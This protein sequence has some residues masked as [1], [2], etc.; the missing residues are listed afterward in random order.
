[1]QTCYWQKIFIKKQLGGFSHTL[2][3]LGKD[4]TKSQR[5]WFVKLEFNKII[6]LKVSLGIFV[7]G[8]D[9]FRVFLINE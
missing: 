1:M 2:L 9:N 4:N 8:L 6:G 7:K 3:K 5:H